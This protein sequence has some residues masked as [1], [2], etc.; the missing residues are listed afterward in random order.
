[1]ARL[2][3]Q[4]SDSSDSFTPNFLAEESG[5]SRAP[6]LPSSPPFMLC[7]HPERWMV[8]GGQIVPDFGRLKLKSGVNRVQHINGRFIVGEARAEKERRGWTVLPI[9]CQGPNTSYLRKPAGT[10]AHVLQFVETFAGSS[11]T[12]FDHEGY[13]DFCSKLLADG[14]ITAPPL[15]IL[16]RMRADLSAM[17][18]AAADRAVSVPSARALADTLAAS[19]DVLDIAMKSATKKAKPTKNKAPT[20]LM[21]D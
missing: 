19:I 4:E 1:M 6:Q 5:R 3:Q 21:E 12:R 13:G 18:S 7:F 17:Q 15:Y 2:K 16:E 8:R 20:V 11:S 9:D 10:D 14:L